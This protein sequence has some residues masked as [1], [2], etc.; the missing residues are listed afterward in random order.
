VTWGL[1]SRIR[2]PL[3]ASH[4]LAFLA[5][6]V[7][8]P[9]WVTLCLL[10]YMTWALNLT[11]AKEERRLSASAF[12]QQ[13]RQYMARTGRFFP[14]PGLRRSPSAVSEAA[15]D[16]RQVPTQPHPETE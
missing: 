16:P 11:A 9:H 13:Y 4:I 2:H 14:R 12:G 7:F 10:G 5:A 3:Y 1:Y 6:A 8:F 15:G